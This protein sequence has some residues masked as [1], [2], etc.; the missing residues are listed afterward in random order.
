MNRLMIASACVSGLLAVAACATPPTAGSATIAGDRAGI[1]RYCVQQT[2]TR[3]RVRDDRTDKTDDFRQRC[4]I[5]GGRVYTREDIERT[6]E[7][8]IGRAL[9]KLDPAIQ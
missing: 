6:G 4:V 5:A 1:D 8:D 2:G 9:R 7:V 3:I